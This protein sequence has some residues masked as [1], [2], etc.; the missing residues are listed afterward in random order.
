VAT[1]RILLQ[2][3]LITVD[4]K[5]GHATAIQRISEPLNNQHSPVPDRYSR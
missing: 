2:G 5:S 4:E 3:C 1:E